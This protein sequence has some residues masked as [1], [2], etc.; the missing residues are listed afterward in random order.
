[1]TATILGLIPNELFT[2]SV[3]EFTCEKVPIPKSAT[4]IPLIAKNIARGFHFCPIPLTM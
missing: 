2:A 4:K 1:M 3:I